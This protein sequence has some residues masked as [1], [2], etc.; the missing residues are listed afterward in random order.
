MRKLTFEL[1]W[2]LAFVYSTIRDETSLFRPVEELQKARRLIL[3]G[4]AVELH[5]PKLHLLALQML[6][7]PPFA[8]PMYIHCVLSSIPATYMSFVA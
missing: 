7:L 2:R 3:P 5:I 6:I 1:K 8:S 4:E